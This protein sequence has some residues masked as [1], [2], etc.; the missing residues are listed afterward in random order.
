MDMGEG[1]HSQVYRA[2]ALLPELQ[3]R[4]VAD[5]LL[6]VEAKQSADVTAGIVSSI[7]SSDTAKAYYVQRVILLLCNLTQS[8]ANSRV[9]VDL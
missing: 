5:G 4:G 1:N 6:P 3:V 7:A 8:F 9:I 2:G